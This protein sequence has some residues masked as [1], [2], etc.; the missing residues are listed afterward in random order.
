[1]YRTFPGQTRGK[2]DLPELVVDCF[3]NAE[4][5]N[6]LNLF[7]V[8]KQA[9]KAVKDL[10]AP[11]A[12]LLDELTVQVTLQSIDWDL[13]GLHGEEQVGDL[14]NEN[15]KFSSLRTRSSLVAS[16]GFAGLYGLVIRIGAGTGPT[17]S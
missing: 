9:R 5:R 2:A 17:S 14:N 10:P 4:K 13:C 8:L 1:L 15:A 12:D 11:E 16:L 6:L 7:S 3:V